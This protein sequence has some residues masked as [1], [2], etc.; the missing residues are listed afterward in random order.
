MSTA[1]ALGFA[2]E[3]DSVEAI[4]M[5]LDLGRDVNAADNQG[6]TAMHGA[7]SRGANEVIRLLVSRGGRL[8][9]MS[10]DDVREQTVDNEPALKIPGQTP[11]DAALDADPPRTATVALIR[12]LLGEDPNAPMRAPAKKR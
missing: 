4:K 2:V 9:V 5:L 3:A 10:K 11:L 12:Q 8:D 6:M 7:A 1:Q